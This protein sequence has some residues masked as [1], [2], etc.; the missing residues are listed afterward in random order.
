MKFEENGVGSRPT[1]VVILM[2]RQ[3]LKDLL[4]A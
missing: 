2:K 4:T 3:R 1:I